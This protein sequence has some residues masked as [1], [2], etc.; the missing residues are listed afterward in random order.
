MRLRPYRP[1][2]V[3]DFVALLGDPEVMRYVGEGVP[4]SEADAT[5]LF[6]RVFEIMANDPTFHIWAV[7]IGG[8]YAGHA[9]LKRRRGK[10]DYE[11]IYYLAR[12]YWGCGHGKRLAAEIVAFG[13]ETCGLSHVIATVAEANAASRRIVESLGFRED[14]R[15][16]RDYG[17]IG[18]LLAR[19]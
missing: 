5:A 6:A 11:L 10:E 7:E 16:S 12:P 18:Y 3:A 15:I 1:A 4:L 2:D 17:P 19:P 9:E 14:A 8:A 13:L